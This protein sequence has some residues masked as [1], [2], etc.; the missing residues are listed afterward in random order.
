VLC[1]HVRAAAFACVTAKPAQHSKAARIIGPNQSK[2]QSRNG[3][4][5]HIVELQ[6][7]IAPYAHLPNAPPFA[8]MRQP[9]ILYYSASQR[10]RGPRLR[11]PA[12]SLRP[13]QATMCICGLS[14]LSRWEPAKQLPRTTA[15]GLASK[16]LRNPGGG[17]A[18]KWRCSGGL[19]LCSSVWSARS[20]GM[21]LWRSAAPGD[22]FNNSSSCVFFWMHGLGTSPHRSV[23]TARAL[24]SGIHQPRPDHARQ[25]A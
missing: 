14:T 4:F 13:R 12:M 25:R 22:G 20:A 2:L 11:A 24:D 16:W 21:P 8:C 7:S 1:T 10:W 5:K 3:T 18:F 6:D 19:A 9:A 15:H 17:P 23:P